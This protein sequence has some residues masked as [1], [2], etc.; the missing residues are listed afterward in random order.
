MPDTIISIVNVVKSIQ[1]YLK[2]YICVSAFACTWI[3]SGR[4]KVEKGGAARMARG[5]VGATVQRETMCNTNTPEFQFQ[6]QHE[7]RC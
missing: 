2:Y 3:G 1:Q 4:G 7:L 6:I 5:R